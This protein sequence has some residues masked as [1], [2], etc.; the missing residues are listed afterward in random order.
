MKA[1]EPFYRYSL[2]IAICLLVLTSLSGCSKLLPRTEE[3]TLSRW[4]KFDQVKA[5]YD[6]INMGDSPEA[7]A[8]LGFNL[9]KSPNLELL[10]HKDLAAMFQNTPFSE[11]DDC[12][13]ECL[14]RP[15]IC[16]GYV[17]DLKQLRSKRVGNFWADFFNFRRITD[18]KGWHFNMLIVLNQE[19]VAYKLW[20]GTRSIEKTKKERNPLGPLQSS[21]DRIIG[22]VN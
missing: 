15:D 14:E 21:G 11:L 5:A 22:L 2:I 4:E 1:I 18:V 3:A 17:Y 20:S 9:Q 7:L 10:N 12:L 6:K 13:R 16:R 8:A 19:Q